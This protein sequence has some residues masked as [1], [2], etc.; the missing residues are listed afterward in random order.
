LLSFIAY[1]N[2]ILDFTC[3][4]EN[5]FTLYNKYILKTSK[6]KSQNNNET[7]CLRPKHKSMCVHGK[8]MKG[9]MTHSLILM[10]LNLRWKLFLLNIKKWIWC[11]SKSIP[12]GGWY[13]EVQKYFVT[14][15]PIILQ[16][17]K[18][19]IDFKLVFHN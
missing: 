15:V 12:F 2:M 14:L 18:A 5:S 17:N 19:L 3:A 7:T 4:C 1:K 11:R 16:K 6:M 8:Q 9:R 10:K 13:L